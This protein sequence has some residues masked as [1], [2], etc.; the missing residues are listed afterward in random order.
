M[1]LIKMKPIFLLAISL[2]ISACGVYKRFSPPD[3]DTQN[4]L[5][6]ETVVD[7]TSAAPTPWR[8]MFADTCLQSLIARGL[9]R[10]T[11]LAVARLQI[12]EAQASLRSARLAYLPSASLNPKGEISRFDGESKKTYNL[13]AE[14]SWEVEIFGKTTNARRGA[15]AALEASEAYA[16]AVQTQM[17]ATIA[18]SYFAL[19]LLDENLSISQQTLATW[20]ENIDMLEA[21]AQAGQSN[22]V[23][24]HQARANRTAL[25]A[26]I[27][28][29][30][31][32]IAQT[33]NSLA[34]LLRE[35]SRAIARSSLAEQA[36]ADS[37]PANGIPL[38]ML[39]NRPD[40]RQAEAELAQAFYSTQSARSA[41][42]PSLTLSGSLGWTNSGSG[43]I[44]NPGKWLAD[45][46]AQLTQTLF[47]HGEGR[48]NLRIAK[49]EQEAAQMQFEQSLYDAG[50]EVNDALAAWQAADRRIALDRMQIADL[51][52]ATEKTRLLVQYSNTNYLEVLTAQQSLLSAQ[53]TLA[54]DESDKALSVIALYRALGG[55]AE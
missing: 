19:L 1:K 22:D 45:A 51:E 49:A 7:T 35:Q 16:Q 3:V 20:D 41:L 42:Y 10:N 29:I 11:D 14:A 48:A 53:L 44:V 25:E 13:G 23:A 34:A 9:E 50:C 8:T 4:L 24:V 43:A 54:E 47:N 2:T 37:L 40:V 31:K 18:E 36:F 39:A 38:K 21:L 26:S 32:N 30:E 17:V 12:A 52:A 46:V 27:V 28:T 33:E 6:E 55:G 5:R 15:Q